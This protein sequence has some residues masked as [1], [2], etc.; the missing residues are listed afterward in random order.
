[1]CYTMGND[2]LPH[3]PSLE[4]MEGGIPLSMDTVK[5]IGAKE[6]RKGF[7]GGCLVDDEYSINYSELNEFFK[8]IGVMEKSLA[9]EKANSSIVFFPDEIMDRHTTEHASDE[10]DNTSLSLMKVI[11]WEEYKKDYYITNFPNTDV[12][13]ICREY[14]IGLQWVLTY[15]LSGVPSWNWCYPYQYAPFASDLAKYTTTHQPHLFTLDKPKD[16]FLQLI[17]VLSPDSCQTLLPKGLKD[18]LTKTS[19]KKYVPSTIEIDVSGKRKEWEG[20]VKLPLMNIDELYEVYNEHLLNVSKNTQTRLNELKDAEVIEYNKT[21]DVYFMSNGKR[22]VRNANIKYIS[23]LSD[24]EYVV[25]S[26]D[27]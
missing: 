14:L 7:D 22:F 23:L 10:D 6:D 19:L 13:T 3:I 16:P 4:I 8:T 21:S 9:E 17:A 1:M 5:T 15:Y 27:D 2:F 20:I 24:D 25:L 18:I 26:E 11:D 12:G